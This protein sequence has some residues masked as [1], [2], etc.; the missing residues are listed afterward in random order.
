MM[1]NLDQTPY[2]NDNDN[3]VGHGHDKDD[4]GGE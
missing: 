2:G 3:D 1:I 4:D